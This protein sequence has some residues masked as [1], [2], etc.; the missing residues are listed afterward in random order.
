MK[1]GKGVS[2]IS[3]KVLN[4]LYKKAF[5]GLRNTCRESIGATESARVNQSMQTRIEYVTNSV[6]VNV[7]YGIVNSEFLD[8]GWR[9]Y[10]Q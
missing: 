1:K 5:S 8:K 9:F 7:R 6:I 2:N 4:V 3:G 10:G